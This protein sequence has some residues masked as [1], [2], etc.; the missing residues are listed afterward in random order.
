MKH[1]FTR[2][3]VKIMEKNNGI[4]ID[5]IDEIKY[6][7][8]VRLFL[9]EVVQNHSMN[10]FDHYVSDSLIQHDIQFGQTAADWKSYIMDHD[11]TNDFV[12]KT[13]GQGN[14]VVSYSNVLIDG[15]AYAQ[16]DLF[17]LEDGKIAEHWSNKEPVPARQEL[18]NS[19]KS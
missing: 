19:G 6:I 16:F 5:R 3:F 17:R 2:V 14:F 15:T 13:I 10:R 9:T 1:D 7:T 4:R 8:L 11:V 12:F 18:I